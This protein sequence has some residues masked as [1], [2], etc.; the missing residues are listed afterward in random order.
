MSM[1]VSAIMGMTVM[2]VTVM[3]VTIVVTMMAVMMTGM[4]FGVRYQRT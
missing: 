4:G 1:S 3:A 2:A